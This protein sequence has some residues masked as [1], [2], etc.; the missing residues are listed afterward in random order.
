MFQETLTHVFQCPHGPSICTTAWAKA[1]SAF[2]KTST[3]PF[4]VATLGNS[5]LQWSTGGWVQ[6]QG[7]TPALDDIIGQVVFTVIQE[8]QSIGWELAIPGWVSQHWGR[9]NTLY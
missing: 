1:I 5:I 2:M 6:W 3:C 8:Q 9:A 7:P 4:I